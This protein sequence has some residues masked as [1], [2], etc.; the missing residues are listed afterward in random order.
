M[1][2]IH[3]SGC[4]LL[5]PACAKAAPTRTRQAR[6]H[7]RVLVNVTAVVIVDE[8]VRERLKIDQ[9][10]RDDEQ[11]ADH[12]RQEALP[13]GGLRAGEACSWGFASA[14]SFARFFGE[15][16]FGLTRDPR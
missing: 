8:V 7:H 14:D 5:Q 13:I 10:H 12:Q 16:S 15:C 9:S 3:V 11:A 4:Q 6:L 1:C 2:E